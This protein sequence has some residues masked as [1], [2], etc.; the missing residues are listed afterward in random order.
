MARNLQPRKQ[1]GEHDVDNFSYPFHSCVIEENFEGNVEGLG[2]LCLMN[3]RN[4]PHL[5]SPPPGIFPNNIKRWIWSSPGENDGNSWC[6]IV[7]LKPDEFYEGERY[8]YFTAWCDYT[9]FDC[10]GGCHFI[11]ANTPE[12]LVEFA[13]ENYDYDRYIK[14]T[15]PADAW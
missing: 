2:G 10:Q 11:T 6:C 1:R 9:G 5:E 12:H 13:L 3:Q 4:I 14:E 8:L 15:E 7:E